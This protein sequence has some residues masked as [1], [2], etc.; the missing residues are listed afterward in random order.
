MTVI[1][2]SV[3]G[4]GDDSRLGNWA[5][6]FQK[7][8]VAS[9][10]PID[11]QGAVIWFQ[12]FLIPAGAPLTENQQERI[13]DTY[14]SGAGADLRPSFGVLTEVQ[15]CYSPRISA[16]KSRKVDVLYLR[17]SNSSVSFR[18]ARIAM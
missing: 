9:S 5:D 1:I 18:S 11:T 4:C 8:Q 13:A 16:R 15:N 14:F 10:K 17:N 12:A 2:L 6:K 7:G 3:T